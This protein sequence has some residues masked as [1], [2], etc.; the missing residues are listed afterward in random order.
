MRLLSTVSGQEGVPGPSGR[1]FEA[2]LRW[3]IVSPHRRGARGDWRS[4]SALRSHRRG[5]WFEPSIAHPWSSQPT[6][7]RSTSSTSAASGSHSISHI[8][9]GTA[10][11]RSLETAM[12]E[13]AGSR[14]NDLYSE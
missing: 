10:M 12:F 14:A 1:W 5:H 13:E 8:L 2:L 3:A 11:T 6:R 9:G 7:G 4:G